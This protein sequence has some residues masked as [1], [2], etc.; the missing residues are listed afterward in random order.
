MDD[1]STEAPRQRVCI[2]L[3]Q[4]YWHAP[5]DV[6]IAVPSSVVLSVPSTIDASTPPLSPT[7]SHSTVSSDSITDEDGVVHPAGPRLIHAIDPTIGCTSHLSRPATSV[8]FVFKNG[9]EAPVHSETTEMEITPRGEEGGFLYST[10][11][12]PQFWHIIRDA[13]DPTQFTI[14]QDIREVEAPSAVIYSSEYYFKFAAAP[15]ALPPAPAVLAPA[16]A[17]QTQMRLDIPVAP[18]A[19]SLTDVSSWASACS[20]TDGFGSPFVSPLSTTSSVFSDASFGGALHTPIYE[21]EADPFSQAF[22]TFLD[23]DGAAQ[24]G[25]TPMELATGTAGDAKYDNCATTMTSPVLTL[26]YPSDN[27]YFAH[28]KDLTSP[29][30]FD[31]TVP[32]FDFTN[33]VDPAYIQ[34]Y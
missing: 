18:P 34:L 22:S 2:D 11:L 12:V 13:A 15:L 9:E 33:T 20:L 32:S 7:Q 17:P 16:P 28:C 6:A 1:V 29:F 5:T 8:F 30:T 25:S 21:N 14:V 19:L 27:D 4:E 26:S 31:P 24:A 23:L 3:I 10:T